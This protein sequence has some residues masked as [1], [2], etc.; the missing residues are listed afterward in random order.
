[1][2]F[3][4]WQLQTHGTKDVPKLRTTKKGHSTYLC[5]V[6]NILMIIFK[7]ILKRFT[8]CNSS[9]GLHLEHFPYFFFKL[10]IVIISTYLNKSSKHRNFNPKVWKERGLINREGGNNLS[11]IIWKTED[12]EKQKAGWKHFQ[13][14]SL[15]S[16]RFILL[17]K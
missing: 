10:Q 7:E 8:S 15:L 17:S 13:K 9:N 12:C 14:S 4:L 5:R 1:M 6:L 16:K 2:I 3:F 11:F